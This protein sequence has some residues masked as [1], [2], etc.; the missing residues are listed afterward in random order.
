MESP[1]ISKCLVIF[2]GIQ[3][4][5]HRI[6][7]HVIEFVSI[8]LGHPFKIFLKPMRIVVGRWMEDARGHQGFCRFKNVPDHLKSFQGKIEKRLC[9]F[10]SDTVFDFFTL[11]GPSRSAESSMP[12]GGTQTDPAGFDNDRLSFTLSE[13]PGQIKPRQSGPDDAGFGLDLSVQGFL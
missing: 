11:T 6:G 13:F 8:N 9:L 1:G 3:D 2:F 4:V 5:S 10:Q 7:F 12:S